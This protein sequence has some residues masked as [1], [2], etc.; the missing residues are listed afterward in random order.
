MVKKFNYNLIHW[1]TV[2]AS[3]L[4]AA[5]SFWL[6]R[7]GMG[8]KDLLRPSHPAVILLAVVSIL[9]VA[10]FLMFARKLPKE[11]PF[12][13]FLPA[14]FLRGVG[15]FIGAIGFAYACITNASTADTLSLLALIMGVVGGVCLLFVGTQR[16]FGMD[17]HYLFYGLLTLFFMIQGLHR[18]RQWSSETQILMFLFPLMAQIFLLMTSCQFTFL[19][20]GMPVIRSFGFYSCCAIFFCF[21]AFAATFDVFYLTCA[22]WLLLDGCFFKIPEK[23]E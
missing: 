14:N 18:C 1:F 23:K 9:A 21:V 17:P 13:E 6:F 10:A 7:D 3:I 19:S 22:L 11:V 8:I 2:V 4:G 5:L 20:Y 16:L 12:K 15:C